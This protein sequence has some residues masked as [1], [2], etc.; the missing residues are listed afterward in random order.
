MQG[1][2]CLFVDDT[3]KNIDGAAT[4][5]LQT[6]WLQNGMFIEDAL[7]DVLHPPAIVN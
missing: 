2:P 4:A 3:L 6:L 7:E 5:G 1:N